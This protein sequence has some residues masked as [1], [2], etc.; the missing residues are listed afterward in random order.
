VAKGAWKEFKRFFR[1]LIKGELT[2]YL[3]DACRRLWVALTGFWNRIRKAYQDASSFVSDLRNADRQTMVDYAASFLG[4]VIGFVLIGGMGD[5]G[6]VDGDIA[7]LGIGGHRSILFHSVLIGLAGEVCFLSAFR[8]I[9]LCHHRLPADHSPIWDR[10]LHIHRRFTHALVTGT[11][12]GVATHLTVDS[13][14]DGWQPYKD[15]PVVL[16][17]WGHYLV[18]D[19]NAAAS[20]WFGWQW[21]RAKRLFRDD[22]IRLAYV[23]GQQTALLEG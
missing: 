1:A 23:D 9:E 15:L 17:A 7:V 11:W 3:K 6:A 13:H 2:A 4:G 14:F 22:S 18:M 21:H 12:A 8:L 10:L 5:G 20:G 19:I 16:P